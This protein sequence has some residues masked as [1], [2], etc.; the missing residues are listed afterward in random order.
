M[1]FIEKNINKLKRGEQTLFLNEIEY[2]KILSIIPKNTY[3]I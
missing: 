3:N 2:K 1:Y